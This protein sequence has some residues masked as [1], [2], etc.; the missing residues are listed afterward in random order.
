LVSWFLQILNFQIQLVPL[1]YGI[2]IATASCETEFQKTYL[3]DAVNADIFSDAML[4]SAAYQACQEVKTPAL[5][6]AGT[7][8]CDCLPVWPV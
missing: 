4:S 3:R 8:F 6:K 1:H 2:A 5:R 7:L